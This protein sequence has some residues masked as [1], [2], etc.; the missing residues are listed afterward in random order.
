M[1]FPHTIAIS[2]LSPIPISGEHYHSFLWSFTATYPLLESL[3]YL[4][5]STNDLL[6]KK[7]EIFNFIVSMVKNRKHK[8]SFLKGNLKTPLSLQ[9]FHTCPLFVIV[10]VVWKREKLKITLCKINMFVKNWKSFFFVR[11]YV[12]SLRVGNQI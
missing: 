12:W 3:V 2:I 7:K 8:Y 6:I 1:F 10:V 5:Q 9:Q 11:S 4:I